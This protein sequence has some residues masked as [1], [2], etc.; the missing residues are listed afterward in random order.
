MHSSTWHA[1]S[2]HLDETIIM[3]GLLQPMIFI[4]IN[5]ENYQFIKFKSTNEP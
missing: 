5:R 4:N 3:D 1:E 2:C